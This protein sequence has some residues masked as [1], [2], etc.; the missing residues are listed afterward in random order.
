MLTSSIR[1][2]GWWLIC[3]MSLVYICI[4]NPLTQLS[5]NGHKLRIFDIDELGHIHMVA[6][7]TNGDV[8]RQYDQILWHDL[9]PRRQYLKRGLALANLLNQLL[10]R[11]APH[12]SK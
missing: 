4:S 8:T 1:L 9:L 7:Y 6:V 5:T 3:V 10:A 11:V 12:K 2:V